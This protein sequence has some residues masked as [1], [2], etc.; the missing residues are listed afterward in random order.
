MLKRY[1]KKPSATITAIRLDLD[2]PGFT[3]EKWGATQ[4]CKPGDWLVNNNGDIYTIDAESFANTYTE[5]GPGV[6]YKSSTVY[7]EPADH[8]GEIRTREG[9]TRYQAGDYLV[10]NAPDREDGYAVSKEKFEAMYEPAQ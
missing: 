9:V 6:Y 3:Y 1:R 8:P 4:H 5:I 2:T 7:A 10:F